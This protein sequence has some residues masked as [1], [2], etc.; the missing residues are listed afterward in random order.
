[1]SLKSFSGDTIKCKIFALQESF[2]NFM[3]ATNEL[4][5][6]M[7]DV[8]S[9]QSRPDFILPDVFWSVFDDFMI[10]WSQLVLSVQSA[11]PYL[12][13]CTLRCSPDDKKAVDFT[14]AS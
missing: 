1:M 7:I 3:E 12:I 8:Q 4:H 6:L 14:T 13:L 11:I 5:C 10:S 2:P 9:T